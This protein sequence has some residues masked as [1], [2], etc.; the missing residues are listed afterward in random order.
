MYVVENIS[1]FCLR[2][3][4]WFF[5]L[6]LLENDSILDPSESVLIKRILNIASGFK[7][8]KTFIDTNISVTGVDRGL[9]GKLLSDIVNDIFGIRFRVFIVVHIQYEL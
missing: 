1:M 3:V 6:Q 5:S 9:G 8:I 7:S 4:M 2:S